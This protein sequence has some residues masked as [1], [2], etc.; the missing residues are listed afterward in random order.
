MVSLGRFEVLPR[1]P[2]YAQSSLVAIYD[3]GRAIGRL[4]G[5]YVRGVCLMWQVVAMV[6]GQETANETGREMRSYLS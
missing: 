6:S 2:N 5:I 1:V 3:D 4:A